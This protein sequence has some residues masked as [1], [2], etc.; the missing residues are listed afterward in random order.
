MTV[1]RPYWLTKS[2]FD[3]LRTLAPNE[4][5]TE[6]AR[7]K[8]EYAKKDAEK[9]QRNR[10]RRDAQNLQNK[11]KNRKRTNATSRRSYAK[12][13]EDPE[14]YAKYCADKRAYQRLY[15]SQGKKQ[16]QTEKRRE[17][18]R[19]KRQRIKTQLLAR[20]NPAEMRKQIRAHVPGYLIASAQ[21]DVI[22]SVMV[23][24]LDR[25]VPFNELAAWVKQAVTAYN[26]QYD[27][28]K[29]ISIDA[30]IAGTDGLTRA[31][32][33]DSETFHF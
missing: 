24:I 6:A 12:R 3:Y 19:R 33:L 22:N 20:D 4:A 9:Y 10:A 8:A 14:R 2:Q 25:K 5:L 27:H 28:F 7:I 1:K 26:R 17:R 16:V 32:L 18:D 11:H 30:P 15:Y 23:Q 31:D 29:N 21:M 13:K